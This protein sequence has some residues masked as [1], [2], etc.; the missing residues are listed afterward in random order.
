MAKS[1]ESAQTEGLRTVDGDARPGEDSDAFYARKQFEDAEV[2]LGCRIP[3]R[4]DLKLA[5]LMY[6]LRRKG[7][8]VTKT[9]L[10]RLAL[11]SLPDQPNAEFHLKL[12]KYRR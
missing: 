10:V 12:D 3:R 6:E 9:D 2:Y 11:D 1:D 5:G 4:Q 8:K 7:L